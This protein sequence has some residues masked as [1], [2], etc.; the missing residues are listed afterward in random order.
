[1]HILHTGCCQS[2]K[3]R[4]WK[5][6]FS[7]HFVYFCLLFSYIYFSDSVRFQESVRILFKLNKV[8]PFLNIY[9]FNYQ[10]SLDKYN[11]YINGTVLKFNLLLTYISSL[12]FL[13]KSEFI[14]F[15]NYALFLFTHFKGWRHLWKLKLK[16]PYYSVLSTIP[17]FFVL[18]MY[19]C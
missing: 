15:K 4:V 2:A 3:Q 17:R 14:C 8:T 6:K 18:E 12:S 19:A 11:S 10:T 7:I 13:W 1:M 16:I 5:T 9:L